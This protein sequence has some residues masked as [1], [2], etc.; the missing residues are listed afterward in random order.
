MEPSSTRDDRYVRTF[1]LL[2]DTHLL[3]GIR[4][5]DQLEEALKFSKHSAEAL[6]DITSSYPAHLVAQ[7]KVSQALYHS[8][9]KKY[10][11]HN[12]YREPKRCE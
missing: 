9:P 6:A 1:C 3:E 10:A 4:L 12:V 2:F 11:T 8:D 7:W 5:R